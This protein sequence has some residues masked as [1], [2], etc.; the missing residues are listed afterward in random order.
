MKS[1]YRSSTPNTTGKK[2]KRNS[3]DRDGDFKKRN[4]I[5]RD[6]KKVRDDAEGT[7]L[8]FI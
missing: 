3:N 7:S 1:I 2:N 5:R 6:K 4:K 8:E